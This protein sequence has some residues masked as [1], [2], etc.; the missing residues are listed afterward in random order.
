MYATNGCVKERPFS[1]MVEAEVNSNFSFAL[2]RFYFGHASPLLPVR[3]FW[4]SLHVLNIF[5]FNYFLFP[6][7][8]SFMDFL[9]LGFILI[10]M[11]IILVDKPYKKFI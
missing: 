8:F 1:A 10:N 3:V 11:C 9:L 4:K 2:G 7:L 6:F 5:S